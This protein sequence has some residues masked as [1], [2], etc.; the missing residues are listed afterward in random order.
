M[1]CVRIS[2]GIRFR[3]AFQNLLGCFALVYFLVILFIVCFEGLGDSP[4]ECFYLWFLLEK[5]GYPSGKRLQESFQNLLVVYSLGC[6]GSSTRAFVRK[7][8]SGAF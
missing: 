8:V 4:I 2:T 7:M 5:H 3:D 6:Y 1:C